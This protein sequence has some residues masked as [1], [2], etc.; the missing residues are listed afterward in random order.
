MKI[1]SQARTGYARSRSF[2]LGTMVVLGS[3]SLLN[4][5]QCFVHGFEYG[6]KIHMDLVTKLPKTR[7]GY[8][9]IWVVVDRLTKSA[10]FLAIREAYTSERMAEIYVNE[11][12]SRHGVP[13]SIVGEGGTRFTSRYCWRIQEEMGTK[14]LVSTAYHP[15]TDGQTERTI[16]TLIDMLR[17]C[18]LDFG[19]SWDEHLPL[20]EFSYNNSY[21]SS[22][23]MAPFEMLYGRKCRTP[24]C[25]GEVGQ[26]ELAPSDLV[27]L[28]N[29]KISLIRA[30]IQ[31][32]QDRQKAYADRRRRPIEFQVGDFVLLKV[33][34]WK[35]IIRFRKRG[36]LGPRYIGPFK[37]LARVGQVA[38]RLELPP[39][40]SGIH[41]TFHVSQLRKCLADETAYVPLEDIEVDD[42]LNYVEK[43]V[44]IRD[45]KVKWLRNKTINK[46]W[47]NGN[48]GRV[49]ILRGN[50]RKKCGSTIL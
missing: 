6:S 3:L 23:Q 26:R 38:Y 17:A 43:P 39:S 11:I 21:H 30:R 35:G 27:A 48:I 16:Q 2:G 10:H 8:D 31:A 46:F 24:V 7:K 13:V 45:S 4:N 15:Q 44:A 32:A 28:T 40:L 29:E 18:V 42:K 41:D 47:F 36:K 12:V 50:P 1:K 22:I 14:L 9:A 49:R 34:P 20:V 19:G 33:S 37:I 5:C 25:W